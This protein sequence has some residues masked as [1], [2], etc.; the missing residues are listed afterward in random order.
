MCIAATPSHST[1][2]ETAHDVY[3]AMLP[4]LDSFVEGQPLE[5][6][7]LL[8][9]TT[10]Q[11]IPVAALQQGMYKPFYVGYRC[12]FHA[13]RC[14]LA[15]TEAVPTVASLRQALALGARG[16]RYDSAAVEY[17]LERGGSVKYAL[18]MVLHLAAC[19]SRTPLGDGT[20]DA[21]WDDALAAPDTPASPMANRASLLLSPPLGPLP[22]GPPDKDAV[23]RRRRSSSVKDILS[24]FAGKSKGWSRERGPA[25]PVFESPE[26]LKYREEWRASG[27][28]GC[29]LD[30]Q[31]VG[32][33]YLVGLH[34]P[35]Q[36]DVDGQDRALRRQECQL[37]R[38]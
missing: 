9:D 23:K 19:L 4:K 20:F 11:F 29:A 31:F 10:L 3:M 7:V 12:A 27:I 37:R 1:A 13:I 38:M 25:V 22:L 17:F 36:W 28:P 35:P 14:F 34:S 18:D 6:T 26:L 16:G 21:R 2:A 24:G 30:D 32:V 33:R 8:E 15:D 5:G